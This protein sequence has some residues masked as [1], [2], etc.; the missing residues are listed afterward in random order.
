[1]SDTPLEITCEDLHARL[2]AGEAIELIDCREPHE[3]EIV[4]LPGARLIP[5]GTIPAAAEDLAT[6]EG[7]VVVYCHHGMRSAQTAQWLREHGLPAAQS[8]AGGVDAWAVRIDPNRPR[9]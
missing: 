1:M 6:L 7:P 9:Y 4:R 2:E 3:H 5:M 8:L